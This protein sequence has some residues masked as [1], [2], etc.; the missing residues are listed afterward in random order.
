M[1]TKIK[2]KITKLTEITTLLRFFGFVLL[3]LEGMLTVIAGVIAYKENFANFIKE[4]YFIAISMLVLFGLVI[5]VVTLLAFFRPQSLYGLLGEMME[6]KKIQSEQ[7]RILNIQ[8]SLLLSFQK[9]AATIRRLLSEY[10]II[11]CGIR[12][13]SQAIATH[14]R[15]KM[16]LFAQLFRYRGQVDDAK[17]ILNYLIK[18]EPNNPRIHSNLAYC[19]EAKGNLQSAIS[20]LH[21]ADELREVGWPR[22]NFHLARL[23][24]LAKSPQNYESTARHHLSIAIK[25]KEF[26]YAAQITPEVRKLL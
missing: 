21:R 1:M 8:E 24:M 14:D 15:E 6:L 19:Y 22:Y 5:A 17:N 16:F 3:S 13:A 10:P 2:Q 18:E 23:Y 12:N 7:S 25:D 11:D 20:E 26:F 4:F 9:D